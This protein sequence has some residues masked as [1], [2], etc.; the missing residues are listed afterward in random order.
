MLLMKSWL[1]SV[2]KK[3]LSLQSKGA[4]MLSNKEEKVWLSIW[5]ACT[6]CKQTHRAK[7]IKV[8]IK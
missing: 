5:P 7:S 2:N 4:S 6:S 3:G 8:Q 1:Y